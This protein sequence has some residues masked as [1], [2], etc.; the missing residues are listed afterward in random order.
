[1][2]I[3]DA[4][5]RQCHLRPEAVAVIED[6]Q[7]HTYRQ[8]H[9][10]L[11][12]A[13]ARL[14]EMGVR[15]HQHVALDLNID[16]PAVVTMLALMR[17][18]AVVSTIRASYPRADKSLLMARHEVAFVVHGPGSAWP[19]PEAGLPSFTALPVDEIAGRP[20]AA[21]ALLPAGEP[22]TPYDAS[23]DLCLMST[24]S[25]STGEKKS[26]ALTHAEVL[27]RQS[28]DQKLWL[29]ESRRLFVSLNFETSVAKALILR[30]LSIGN[31]LITS[32]GSAA[33]AFYEVLNRDRPTRIVTAT[34]AIP[35]L[36]NLS[37]RTPE[38][39]RLHEP[40]TASICV[41]G[42]ALPQAHLHWMMEHLGPNVEVQLGSSEASQTGFVDARTLIERPDVSSLLLPWVHMQAVDEAGRPLPAGQPGMLRVRS[43]GLARGYYRDPEATARVF[44]DGWF[45]SGDM[46][47]VDEAGYVRLAGRAN[48]VVNL[49]GAKIN[50]ERVESLLGEHPGIV[51]AATLVVERGG[52]AGP[53]LVAVVAP[54]AGIDK[55]GLTREI[56]DL[57][58]TRLGA[59]HVPAVVL[60]TRALPRNSGGKLERAALAQHVTPMFKRSP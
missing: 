56:T 31:T 36:V 60:F 5:I 18:G 8:L 22:E 4:V 54:Q 37:V 10:R 25:G 12:A 51:E 14:R 7:A 24:T 11:H 13:A 33:N 48:S 34:G 29:P 23:G 43:P 35:H 16:L 52:L 19:T 50:L 38:A 47:S 41:T 32:T 15:R 58:A 28:L 3:T 39:A 1:M 59:G 21:G 2:N 46:G 55:D 17:L 6:G 9:L 42:S 49:G 45:L 26:I 57:C 27:V 20:P 40:T 30:A 44:R 53:A